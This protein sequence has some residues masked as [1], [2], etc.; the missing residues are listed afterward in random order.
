MK[1]ESKY[2]CGELVW[3]IDTENKP[4]P[5]AKEMLVQKIN[6]LS[7]LDGNKKEVTAIWYNGWDAEAWEQIPARLLEENIF[8]T[9]EELL[10][11]L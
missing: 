1:I 9:K 4:L 10:N 6:T 5:K 8:K 3:Y 7:W 2:K 11:S